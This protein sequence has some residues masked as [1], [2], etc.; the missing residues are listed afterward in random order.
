PLMALS[1]AQSSAK[2]ILIPFNQCNNTVVGVANANINTLVHSAVDE[3][4]KHIGC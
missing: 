1:G 4:K 2:R 3:L